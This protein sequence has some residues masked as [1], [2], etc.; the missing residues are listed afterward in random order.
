[1]E[2]KRKCRKRKLVAYLMKGEQFNGRNG[3]QCGMEKGRS[4]RDAEKSEAR[5]EMRMKGSG[6]GKEKGET[7]IRGIRTV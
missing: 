6:E 7:L 4:S 3:K 2:T 5:K 1:M